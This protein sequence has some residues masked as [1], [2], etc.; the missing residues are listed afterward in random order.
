MDV[1][2]ALGIFQHGFGPTREFHISN[3]EIRLFHHPPVAAQIGKPE[4][5]RFQPFGINGRIE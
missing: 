2:F 1:I 5:D 4:R 3:E